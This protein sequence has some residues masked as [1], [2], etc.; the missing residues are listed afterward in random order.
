MI[1]HAASSAFA[2]SA[3]VLLRSREY[4]SSVHLLLRQM[5]VVV[6]LVFLFLELVF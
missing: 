3:G 4:P 2:F 6:A 5:D 1:A